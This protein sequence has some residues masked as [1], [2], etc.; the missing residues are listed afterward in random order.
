V[1][2]LPAYHDVNLPAGI[3]AGWIGVSADSLYKI[4][5]EIT[6]GRKRYAD[7]YSL[8]TITSRRTLPETSIRL[9]GLHL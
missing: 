7:G 3:F 8:Q 5:N 9:S 1:L 4:L 2:L 6:Y